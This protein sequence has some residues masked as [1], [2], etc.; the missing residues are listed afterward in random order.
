MDDVADEKLASASGLRLPVLSKSDYASWEM[1]FRAYAAV[2]NFLSALKSSTNPHLPAKWEDPGAI[3]VTTGDDAAKMAAK[4]KRRAIRMNTL[5][6]AALTLSFKDPY[7]K[8]LV[9]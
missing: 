8:G 4:L 3:D 9:R 7:H 5:A 1:D 2:K 6:M